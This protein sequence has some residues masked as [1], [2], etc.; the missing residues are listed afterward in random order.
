[1]QF[2]EELKLLV[3]KLPP[4]EFRV[5]CNEDKQPWSRITYPNFAFR[6]SRQSLRQCRKT[7]VT[8]YR[9]IRTSL[10]KRGVRA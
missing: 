10:K 6:K 3:P 5:L 1:M 4:C 8:R 7:L 9:I 2:F